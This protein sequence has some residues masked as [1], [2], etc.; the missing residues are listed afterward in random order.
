M[1]PIPTIAGVATIPS[2]EATFRVMLASLADQVDQLHVYL[3][4][5]TAYLTGLPPVCLQHKLPGDPYGDAGKFV[6][7]NDA[8][9]TAYDEGAYFLSLDDDLL[10]PPNYVEKLIAGIER[11]ERSAVCSFH[12]RSFG[13]FPIRNYYR[14]AI[15]RYYCLRSVATDV[16]VQVAGT[17]C[18]G[19]HTSMIELSMGDFPSRSMAD[20]HMAVALQRQDFQAICLKHAAGWI[21]QLDINHARSLYN[22]Y[23]DDCREQTRRIN[24]VFG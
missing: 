7:I 4:G 15:Q 5:H 10:Y 13:R 11:Y 9:D 8:F 17:G 22:R 1:T 20:V 19:F 3:S 2:R 16:G 21:K 6:G 24:E 18:M 23:K 12:G 14:D